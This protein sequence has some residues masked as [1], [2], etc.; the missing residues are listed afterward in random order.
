MAGVTNQLVAWCQ[1]PVAAA[2]RPRIRRRGRD[3]RAGDHR[4]AGDRAA[5]DRRRGALL[6]GLADPDPHR[7]RARQGAH[8]RHRGRRPDPRACR[9]ARS[10]WWPASRASAPTTASPRSAAAARTPRRWRWRR[11]CKADRCDIYTDVDGVYTTDPRIV[12]KARKLAQHHLRGDAGAGL[13]RRQGAADP[14]R[15]AGDERAGARAGAV[16]LRRDERPRHAGGGRG[17]DRGKAES[18]P[19]S[20]IRATRPRSRCAACRTGRASRRRSSARWP[21][22]TSTST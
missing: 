3:R 1:E 13:G 16:E 17:R 4:P 2:R 7:R 11:R 8:R 19:A 20:P 18:C 14:Q 21:S 9:R 22:T 15:R 12:P 5:G 10:P 6:A